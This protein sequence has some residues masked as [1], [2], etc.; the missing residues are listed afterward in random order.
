LCKKNANNKTEQAMVSPILKI[1]SLVFFVAFVVFLVLYIVEVSNAKAAPPGFKVVNN[2]TRNENPF[3][4]F[5]RIYYINLDSRPDRRIQIEEEFNRM[6]VDKRRLQRV[7]GVVAKFGALGCSMAH[8][9]ALE[10]CQAHGWKNCLI[11]EDDLVFKGSKHHVCGQ[12]SQ[13]WEASIL[14]DVLM[15]GSNTL[16]FEPTSFDFLIH[17][18][19]AQ[20][21][22]GYAVNGSF[23][24]TLL[25]NF[26]EGVANLEQLEEAKDEFCIDAF[27]KQLQPSSRWYTFHPVIAHQRDG[28]SNIQNMNTSYRDKLELPFTP[29]KFEFIIMVKTCAP[30]LRQNQEQLAALQNLAST[31]KVCYFFYYGN[32]D[33]EQEFVVNDLQ[34]TLTVK[35]KDD[36]LNLC[37]KFGR[38]IEWLHHFT[39]NNASAASLK[40]V[41]FTDDDI[42]LKSA[43]YPMLRQHSNVPFWGN[44][45][46]QDH[47][48]STHFQHRCRNNPAFL[49]FVREKYPGLEHYPIMLQKG[50]SASG[51]GFYLRKDVFPLILNEDDLFQGFPKDSAALENHKENGA[52]TNIC[53]FD[54]MNVGFALNRHGIYPVNMENLESAAFW[55]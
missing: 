2:V 9:A 26:K 3:H 13:F 45:M 6:G 32:P 44:K 53:A 18:T 10:D 16:D 27:W 43:L 12:L 51:G 35:T 38:M 37:H 25:E 28:F 40:G 4:R 54:D 31:G 29:A 30:R 36:Y 8:I 19:N 1:A 17:T 15:F 46:V 7:Q 23:V 11:V 20:T 48:T 42:E 22:S 41:F 49:T 33:Q 34:R 55:E 39:Q 50:E 5:D 47:A 14:W 52:Y 21:T 24:D